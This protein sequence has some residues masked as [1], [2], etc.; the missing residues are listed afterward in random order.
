MATLVTSLHIIAIKWCALSTPIAKLTKYTCIKEIV[1]LRSITQ[2]QVTIKQ[3]SRL[4]IEIT[5]TQM[6]FFIVMYYSKR[7]DTPFFYFNL[8]LEYE[9]LN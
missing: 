6:I 2:I 4:I 5:A 3:I 8:L 7:A 1:K 9:V